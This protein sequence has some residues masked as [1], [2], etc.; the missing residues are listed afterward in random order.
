MKCDVLVVGASPAG[1]MAA[2]KAGQLGSEVILMDKNLGSWIT[3]P[4]PLRG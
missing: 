1:I 4:T 2:I 3:P